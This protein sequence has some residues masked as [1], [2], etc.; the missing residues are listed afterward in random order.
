MIK[1]KQIKVHLDTLDR[2]EKY[3][4]HPRETLD[5]LINNVLNQVGI[6]KRMETMTNDICPAVLKKSDS[7]DTY[8]CTI[9]NLSECPY[10]GYNKQCQIFV[11]A[12]SM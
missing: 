8:L 2:L 9:S 3:R 7:Q 6:Y 4:T 12:E 1:G 11:D 5:D 10:K